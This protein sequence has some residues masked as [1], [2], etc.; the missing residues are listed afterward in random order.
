M[1]SDKAIEVLKKQSN[2]YDTIL[3]A[4]A[5]KDALAVVNK[6]AE[7]FTANHSTLIKLGIPSNHPYFTQNINDGLMEK[8]RIYK[9]NL[10]KVE[11]TDPDIDADRPSTSM[12]W[13]MHSTHQETVFS[14]RKASATDVM[15]ELVGK[16]A[17]VLKRHIEEVHANLEFSNQEETLDSKETLEFLWNKVQSTLTDL[18]V[19]YDIPSHEIDGIDALELKVHTLSKKLNRKLSVFHSMKED[20]P[21]MPKSDLP[22][23]NGSPKEWPTFFNLFSDMVHKRKDI[24]DTR[25]LNYLKSCLKG[26]AQMVV[27]HLLSGSAASYNS[28][29]EL[30]CKRYENKRKIFANAVNQLVDM[31]LLENDDESRIRRFLD[32]ANENIHIVKEV[33][34]IGNDADVL[35]A[36]IL[37]RRFS[38]EVLQLYEQHVKRAREIQSLQ[39]V[40]E[41]VDQLYNSIDA[42]QKRAAQTITEAKK[43]SYKRCRFCKLDSHDITRCSRFK[44]EPVKKRKEF[45]T[46]N[47]LCFKC[48]G[49]HC[50]KDCKR[51]LACKYCTKPHNNLLHE[52]ANKNETFSSNC[53]K[54]S[55]G[56]DTLLATALIRI[57]NKSGKYEQLRA[58]I[59][60]GSQRT[61]ISEEAAQQ[62]KL[63]R[64]K[65]DVEVQGISQNT[66]I[67]K[68]SV[69]LTI[70]PRMSSK[71]VTSTQ[72]LVMPK[73][74]RA[75]PSKKID[76]DV[77]KDWMGCELADPH[78]NEPSRIDVVIGVDLLPL[79]MLGNVKKVNETLGQ[80]TELGWIVSGNIARSSNNKVIS[81]TTTI[82]LD[83]L[84]RFWELESNSSDSEE[85]NDCE[86]GNSRKQAMARLMQMEKKFKKH[87]QLFTEYK[88]FME[89]YLKLGHM[90][91]VDTIGKG[92]Y[93]MPHQAVIRPNSLTTKLRV[94]FDA[95]AKTT[96]GL[97]LND[98]M[99]VGPKIQ[100]DIFDILIKW[101][102]WKYVMTADIEK[103]YRQIKVAKADQE[104]QYIL[105]RDDPKMP[106][107][108][109]KLTT[110]TYGTSA[111]P[112]LA[113][114]CLQ[115]LANQHCQGNNQ[116]MRTI[117]EDFYMD[118]LITGGDSI[119]DC[120]NTQTALLSA[121]RI[122]DKELVAAIKGNSSIAPVLEREG[123]K[124]HFIPPASPHM[125]GIWEA[126]IKSVKHHLKR[127]IGDNSFTFEEFSTLLCQI[128][129]IDGDTCNE[130]EQNSGGNGKRNTWR[131]CNSEPN[132]DKQMQT[133]QKANLFY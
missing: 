5:E 53:L 26:D 84:E 6:L 99:L 40:L 110:V 116:L 83:D 63:R 29:W 85:N 31:E 124:W 47:A 82:R 130:S 78:F 97:S 91:P 32:T 100:K 94:V 109:Y 101:R 33:A 57:K 17:L 120:I 102:Q 92:K 80:K 25:K 65:R 111:A 54:E 90:E 19:K 81:A 117:K 66:E 18:E 20:V 114:R 71:F 58:L 88:D 74:Q 125:G 113:V 9:E 45:V 73:L 86:K 50:I 35:I 34:Q 98:V 38:T 77:N 4:I 61:L 64:I 112:F 107:K 76:M 11:T 16:R 30:I 103:M 69:C 3:K 49:A 15:V 68:N 13:Q 41:F 62:L 28:A 75:L 12:N 60:G 95:S 10:M 2:L 56:Q 7:E 123:I 44:A 27:S 70:K 43:T 46:K 126:G 96:N 23:F 48:L 104:Y 79:I 36:Q 72:A 51:D 21:E 119:E 1:L 115:E 55:N 132:G 106:I 127:V 108:E 121:A 118:D 24:S 128:E 8:I 59:D 87:P 52:E 93:Y 105:W 131:R 39:N 42:V 129:A 22:Q 67:L 133:S 122:L 37:L 89:Q 14:P